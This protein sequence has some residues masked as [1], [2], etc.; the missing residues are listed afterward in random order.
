VLILPHGAVQ[1][2]KGSFLPK[3]GGKTCEGSPVFQ[4]NNIFHPHQFTHGSEFNSSTDR[5]FFRNDE[6]IVRQ[7][8]GVMNNVIELM[9]LDIESQLQEKLVPVT[10]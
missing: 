3:A 2:I 1:V 10:E 4:R 5:D 9:R 6:L 8:K 7:T